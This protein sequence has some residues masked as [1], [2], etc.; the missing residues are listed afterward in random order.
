[1][2]KTPSPAEI[3]SFHE[4]VL[5]K[6]ALADML[7]AA[8]PDG[9]SLSMPLG[10]RSSEVGRYIISHNLEPAVVEPLTPAQIDRLLE[11]VRLLFDLRKRTGKSLSK[12]AQL[13]SRYD[14]EVVDRRSETMATPEELEEIFCAVRTML[15]EVVEVAE[16]R[17]IELTRI[18]NEAY[19]RRISEIDDVIDKLHERR[20]DRMPP[21]N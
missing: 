1:M 8:D 9:P 17:M 15:A 4:E 19:E 11:V 7:A 14:N 18:F 5:T 3:K 20:D 16:A 2:T 6:L 13:L 10:Q 21:L 12:L